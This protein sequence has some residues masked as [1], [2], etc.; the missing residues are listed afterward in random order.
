MKLKIIEAIV[1]EQISTADDALADWQDVVPE[2]V[3]ELTRSIDRPP[4]EKEEL[5]NG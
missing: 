5:V 2:S 1:V 4:D 3:A